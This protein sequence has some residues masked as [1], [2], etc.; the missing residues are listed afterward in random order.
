[1]REI[2]TAAATLKKC[3]YVPLK[4]HH[5]HNVQKA[6]DRKCVEKAVLSM[7]CFTFSKAILANSL[8][9]KY[10]TTFKTEFLLM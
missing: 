3:L 8:K 5:F 1:M 10:L 9:P 4:R 2:T 7:H 6:V